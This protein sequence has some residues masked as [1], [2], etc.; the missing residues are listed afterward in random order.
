MDISGFSFDHFYL[1]VK[2]KCLKKNDQDIKISHRT[3]E[4]LHILAK[5]SP[6]PVSKEELNALLWPNTIVS[7]WS[8]ARLISDTRILLGDDGNQQKYIQTMRS[9]GFSMP[10]VLL[11]KQEAQGNKN[12]AI[13]VSFLGAILLFLLILGTYFYWQKAVNNNLKKSIER[14]AHYQDSTYTAFKAQVQRRNQLAKLL[15]QRLMFKRQR[16]WEMF[17]A[18]YYPKMNEAELFVCTQM[19][20]ITN[21]GLYENNL[22]IFN[23]LESKPDIYNEIALTKE[24]Y[25]HLNFWLQKHNNVFQ[26][27]KDMCLLYVGVEDEAPYP[28]GVDQNIKNWLNTH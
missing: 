18:Y 12:K 24:L 17:F 3:F 28:S 4:L 25:Q 8:I 27:R 23:E 9:A 1:D 11:H 14:I 2:R 6:E 13:I 19:R 26:Q 5:A 15:E 16:Q 20:A 10:A 22:A 21:H 7:E